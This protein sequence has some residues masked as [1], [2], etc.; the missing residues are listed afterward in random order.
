M[1]GLAGLAA[2][3]IFAVAV[4]VLAI[5]PMPAV[6]ALRERGFDLF[7]VAPEQ[8]ATPAVHVI[9]TARQG[10]SGAA[11][12]RHDLAAVIRQAAAL[13]PA[14]IGIDILLAG[15]CSGAAAEDLAQTLATAGVPIVLGFLL[16]DEPSLSPGP[17]PPLAVM[18]GAP[19]WDAAG[20][21]G[22]CPNFAASATVALSAVQGNAEGRVRWLP[23]ATFV[24][25]RPYP[26][27]SVELAR[28]GLDLPPATLGHT[29]P[30]RIGWLRFGDST[31]PLDRFGQYRIAPTP[32]DLRA[33][34]THGALD[35]LE[36]PPQIAPGSV[37]LI[38]SALPESGGLRPSRI[39]PLHPT[40]HLQA[41]GVEQVMAGQ[42]P[43]RP[44]RAAIAEAG[45][46]LAG[47]LA[48]GLLAQHFAP[49]I[50]MSGAFAMAALWTVLVMTMARFGILL[51]ALL[52]SLAILGAAGLSLVMAATATRQLAER[53]GDRMRRHLPR[54]VVLR[55]NQGAT[56][57]LTSETREITALFTDIEGFTALT[58]R[59]PT[60]QVVALL[61]RYMTL[62]TDLVER[63]GGMVDKIVGDAVHAFFNAPDNL[64]G[65]VDHA[66]ACAVAIQQATQALQDDPDFAG[67]GF[68]RTRIGVETGIALLGDVG[69]GG[70][71]DYTAHGD[72]VNMAARLQEAN[73]DLGTS[74][75]IGPRAAT[76]ATT[77]LRRGPTIDL[78]SFGQVQV[79]LPVM[80]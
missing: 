51:D 18:E 79:S 21:D 64:E 3:V 26:S 45:V 20:A 24:A 46:G 36:T 43:Q 25:G 8:R 52:P 80:A 47:G 5:W 19:A 11:W 2:A 55:L 40:L 53:L 27:L 71:V 1:R 65:H 50:A 74:V 34:R 42:I 41:D 57:R 23:A 32:P 60:A 67:A 12:S 73:K 49:L 17:Q 44:H 10:P 7:M 61:D 68:G 14:V 15:N 38:G 33:D 48:A 70:R 13:N 35:V 59:V 30:D 4:A 78:R 31:L 58:H 66:I 39:G 76:L 16:V 56:T 37:I 22:P 63:H 69:R 77:A 9:E 72:A 54:S 29:P 28:L 6:N 62:V 75:L